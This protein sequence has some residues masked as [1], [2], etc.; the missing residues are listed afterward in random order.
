MVLG[1]SVTEPP[2]DPVPAPERDEVC[3]LLGSLSDTPR[4]AFSVDVV[5]GVKMMTI[6]QVP[7]AATV[8]PTAGHVLLL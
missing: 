3:G 8:P 2:D 5:L 4:V 6:V 1:D 7:L